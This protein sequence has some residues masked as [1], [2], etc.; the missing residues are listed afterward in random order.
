[1]SDEINTE[2][3]SNASGIEKQSNEQNNSENTNDSSSNGTMNNTKMDNVDI[4]ANNLESDTEKDSHMLGS[5]NNT[6]GCMTLLLDPEEASTENERLRKDL[7]KLKGD[8]KASLGRENEL[9]IKLQKFDLQTV[10][11]AELD[12]L[13]EELRDQLNDALKNCTDLS[14]KLERYE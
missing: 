3:N 12:I 11:I 6:K 5:E 10:Q 1:M 8:L 14:E 4:V 7:A 9:S 13:N 2:T